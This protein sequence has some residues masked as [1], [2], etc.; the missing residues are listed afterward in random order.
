MRNT[1]KGLAAAASI[2]LV[3]GAMLVMLTTVQATTS[4][5][6]IEVGGDLAKYGGVVTVYSIKV[7]SEE[8]ASGIAPNVLKSVRVDQRYAEIQ[9][10]YPANERHVYSFRPIGAA[11]PDARQ[12]THVLSIIGANENPEGAKLKI[13]FKDAIPAGGRIIRVP[14]L[15]EIAGE[16]EATRTMARWGEVVGGNAVPPADPRSARNLEA[17]AGEEDERPFYF[18]S[19]AANVQ[20]CTLPA[21]RWPLMEMRWWR[22]IAGSRLERLRHHALRRC[23]DGRKV[24]SSRNCEPVPGSDEPAYRDPR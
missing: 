20:V 19:G 5:V 1:L 7:T 24:E 10:R 4:E 8:W 11:T 15:A 9:L 18:C 3:V 12:V 22:S 6:T 16:D 17:V 14:P 21:E 2:V 13:G 23:Y